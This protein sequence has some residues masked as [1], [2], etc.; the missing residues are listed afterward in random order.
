MDIAFYRNL[1]DNLYEGVY[2]V[3]TGGRITYWNRSA[4]KITGYSSQ[5]VMGR[6]CSDNILMHIDHRGV[7]LC[8]EG[9]PLSRTMWDG[10]P[11]EIS[12]FLHHKEGYR[13]PVSIR[14]API[15]DEK[16]EIIGAAEI[17]TDDSPEGD[18]S[19][20]RDILRRQALTDTLT[21]AGNR[22][23]GV[24]L[25]EHRIMILERENISFGL[26]MFDVDRFTELNDHY[27]PD[28]ADR[29]LKMTS[30]TVS[31][32]LRS[33]DTLCR[34]EDDTFI[35]ISPNVT[36]EALLDIAERIRV[37]VE[38]SWIMSGSNDRIQVTVS[39]G[40]TMAGSGDTS[41]SLIK[42]CREAMMRHQVEGHNRVFC[43]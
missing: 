40:C 33:F 24:L 13:L 37:F 23:A 41:T 3:D 16:G 19:A 12:A 28:T 42:R 43:R 30:R 14:V 20:S 4:E 5:E 27:G 26:T 18:I 39:V 34:W 11:R 8:E 38:N 22:K 17:F 21:E 9:C 1:I 31:S 32:I 36:R 10:Q 7:N 25:L 35:V 6:P 29:T 2:Y 15:R